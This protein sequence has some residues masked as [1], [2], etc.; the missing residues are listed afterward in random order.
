MS[1]HTRSPPYSACPEHEYSVS[2]TID[3][4]SSPGHH[5]QVT[6]RRELNDQQ[7]KDDK[8]DEEDMDVVSE[9]QRTRISENPPRRVYSEDELISAQ[10]L[11]ELGHG[12]KD[13]RNRI[14]T[15]RRPEQGMSAQAP[16]ARPPFQAQPQGERLPREQHGRGGTVADRRPPYQLRRPIV[17][18]HQIPPLPNTENRPIPYGLA[19]PRPAWQPV[20]PPRQPPPPPHRYQHA[21]WQPAFPQQQQRVEASGLPARSYTDYLGAQRLFIEQQEA[22]RASQAQREQGRQG[23]E[24]S[25]GHHAAGTELGQMNQRGCPCTVCVNARARR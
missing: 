10:A 24:Q 25:R 11:L 18:H 22:N 2:R 6:P 3:T 5:Q 14:E 12:N 8:K 7:L 21:P 1:S 4:Y 20:F 17:P 15:E 9:L 16:A 13:I 19:G 23:R